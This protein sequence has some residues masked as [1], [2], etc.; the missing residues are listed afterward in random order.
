MPCTSAQRMLTAQVPLPRGVDPA[1][2]A[3]VAA[4][5]E[6]LVLLDPRRARGRGASRTPP[7]VGCRA[8]TSSSTDGA[9]CD[10][11]PSTRVARCCTLAMRDDRRLGLVV[12]VGAPRQQRVVDHVDRDLVL[13]PV[14][15]ARPASAA[16]S[17]GVGVGIGA[18]GSGA[19]HRLGPHEVAVAADEQLRAGA[20]EPVDVEQEA[21]G[22]RGRAGGARTAARSNGA[23][24]LD[25][26]L[27]GQHDLRQARRGRRRGWAV[28]RATRSHHHS[29]VRTG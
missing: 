12:E 13:V 17:S 22:V 6:A 9:G 23:V 25:E 14:G 11:R 1:D 18:P 24:G 4:A 15:G 16:A 5:V 28:A 19:G 26:E 3:G 2:R 20:E 21:V 7:G 27:A 29:G 10:S 8:C